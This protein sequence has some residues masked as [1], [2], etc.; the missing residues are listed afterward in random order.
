MGNM[1]I[2]DHGLQLDG[3]AEFLKT[4]YVEDIKS[5]EVSKCNMFLKK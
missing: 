2:T 4:I 1:K 5:L 3:E